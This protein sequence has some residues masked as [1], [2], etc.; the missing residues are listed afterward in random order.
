MIWRRRWRMEDGR[1]TA[2]S[3]RC[4]SVPSSILNPRFLLRRV[5]RRRTGGNSLR[6]RLRICNLYFL[7]DAPIAQLDRASDYGSEGYRFNSYWV[8]QIILPP[9]SS[10]SDG[11]VLEVRLGLVVASKWPA[12][13]GGNDGGGLF[14][15]AG[16]THFASPLCA[17]DENG[18]WKTAD[19]LVEGTIENEPHVLK[20][21]ATS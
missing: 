19:R 18:R 5:S 1:W 2:N 6:E 10:Q 12:V 20:H 7:F 14:R 15:K 16:R 9:V 13:C 3:T 17:V 8:R 4:V 21:T 11:D